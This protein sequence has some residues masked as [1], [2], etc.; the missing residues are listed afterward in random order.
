MV[1]YFGTI[2]IVR[3]W[4]TGLGKQCR[5]RSACSWRSTDQ[6]LHCLGQ[7][8]CF[9]NFRMITGFFSGVRTFQIFTACLFIAHWYTCF[10][11]SFW[12]K[13]CFTVS[14]FY[15]LTYEGSIDL[16]RW[17]TELLILYYCILME[18]KGCCSLSSDCAND[19]LVQVV[20]HE[21]LTASL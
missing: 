17:V 18:L 3:F 12:H 1:L 8:L 13:A 16:D 6:G 11:T 19:W 4:Q 7:G 21:Y 5:P 9:S 14:V 15:Y 2:L 10:R 20:G